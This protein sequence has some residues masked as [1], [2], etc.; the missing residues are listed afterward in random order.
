[1]HWVFYRSILLINIPDLFGPPTM[2]R[3][4]Y[5]SIL[6]INKYSRSV[7][8]TH[9]ALGVL[10]IDFINQYSK[11]RPP[12]M[13]WVFYRSILSTNIPD[14][15]HPRCIGCFIDQFYWSIFQVWTTHDALSWTHPL[16]TC[17]ASVPHSPTP[18]YNEPPAMNTAICVMR[19]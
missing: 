14:L 17:P 1:M 5:R 3:V 10:S 15:D 16:T 6:S 19:C 2:H 7:W 8:T 11:S 9:D 13:H 4:F 18:A 12:T